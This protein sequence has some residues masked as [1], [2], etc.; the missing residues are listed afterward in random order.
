[1][2]GFPEAIRVSTKGFASDEECAQV[3]PAVEM[4]AALASVPKGSIREFVTDLGKF[5]L[6]LPQEL[7]VEPPVEHHF[8]PGLYAREMFAP[9]GS[10]IISRIHKVGCIGIL[11]KGKASIWTE[12]GLKDYEAPATI[13]SR[14][15]TRRVG[16]F[17]EDSVFTAIFATNETDIEKIEQEIATDDFA[18]APALFIDGEVVQ[19]QEVQ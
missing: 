1:M 16:Y 4:L 14:P 7:R 10:L 2:S 17:H 6:T 15:G 19:A 5:M 18:E 12:E 11:S 13:V 8:S 9:K 3:D